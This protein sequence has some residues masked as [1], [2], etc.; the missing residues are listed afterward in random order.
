M[1]D[2]ELLYKP[3]RLKKK[4][5][6]LY[7]RK[8]ELEI[9][10]DSIPSHPFGEPVVHGTRDLNAPFVK[11]LYKIEDINNQIKAVEDELNKVVEQLLT[12]ISL[13]ENNDY[14]DVLILYYI[15]GLTISAITNKIFVSLKTA[16]RWK[17]SAVLEFEKL[18]PLDT[19]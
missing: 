5:H 9:F 12:Y 3:S 2:R 18:T 6:H 7:L 13:I 8:E 4:L 14:Q 16:K 1:L 10:A 11:W 17:R 19:K 15:N